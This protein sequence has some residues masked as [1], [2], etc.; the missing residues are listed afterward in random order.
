MTTPMTPAGL[1]QADQAPMAPPPRSLASE[2][3]SLAALP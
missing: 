1:P 2:Q 3:P